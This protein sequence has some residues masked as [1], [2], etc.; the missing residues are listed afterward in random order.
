VQSSSQ[1]VTTNKPTSNFLQARCPSCHPSNSVKALKGS[2]LDDCGDDNAFCCWQVAD[3]GKDAG[4]RWT[5]RGSSATVAI[6]SG[7]VVPS[8]QSTSAQHMNSAVR[9]SCSSTAT[10]FSCLSQH[11]LTCYCIYCCIFIN[12]CDITS[13][14]VKRWN[15]AM[16]WY[17]SWA[18][19]WNIPL[20]YS[21]TL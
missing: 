7:L 11:C 5:H 14:T 19:R 17:H 10:T 15:L 9:R 21:L 4:I 12:R 13:K 20:T 18:L 2:C 6:W 16:Q 8:I 1:I 3:A